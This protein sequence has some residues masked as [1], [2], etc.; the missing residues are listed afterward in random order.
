MVMV[1]LQKNITSDA[2]G[3]GGVIGYTQFSPFNSLTGHE[4][5]Y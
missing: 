2:S 4:Y 5:V 1:P 3:A